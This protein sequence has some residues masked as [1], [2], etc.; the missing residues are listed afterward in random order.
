MPDSNV[1]VYPI[2]VQSFDMVPSTSATFQQCCHPYPEPCITRERLSDP[3]AVLWL[4]AH[5]SI[6]ELS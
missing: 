2:L 5:G 6:H 1:I 3:S 4:T